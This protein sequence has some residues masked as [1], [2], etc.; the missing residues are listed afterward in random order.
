VLL[1]LGACTSVLG[2][3]DLHDGPRPGA[4]GDDTTAGTTTTGG[5][6]NAGGKNGN[7]GS[8]NPNAGSPEP[9]AGAGNEP[10]GG[11]GAEAGTGNDGG[12]GGSGDNPPLTGPVHGKLIDRWGKVIANAT[13]QIG[14]EQVSSDDKGL[15]TVDDVGESYDVSMLVDGTGWVFQGLTLRNPTLQ[16]Y[17]GS[18]SRYTYVDCDFKPGT[19]KVANEELTVAMSTPTGGVETTDVGTDA[20]FYVRPQWEGSANT[21]GTAHALYWTVNPA[22]KLPA[23][24]KAYDTKTQA[25][26]DGID[27]SLITFDIGSTTPFTAKAITG[28]VTPYG[29][30]SR[31]NSVFMRFSSGAS[32]QIVDHEPTLDAFSYLAPEQISNASFTVAAWEGS[33]YGPLGLVHRNGVSPGEGVGALDI[34]A[35]PT[36]LTP[37]N[38]AT[39]VD[40][41]TNFSFKASPDNAGTFLVVL[42]NLDEIQRLYIVTTQ[43][44]FTVPNVVDGAFV[45]A[46]GTEYEWWVETHGSFATVDA[47]AGPTGWV[48]EFSEEYITPVGL[49]QDSGTYTYSAAY[50]FTTKP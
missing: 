38:S 39:N 47:M 12:T 26:A 22:T 21:T 36:V 17:S 50:T 45:L 23:V 11:T 16:I 27:G 6:S 31:T 33:Y 13:V 3:E 37:P 28:T 24:Y 4:G 29:E 7:G 1:G 25:L 48:D 41:A 14:A 30:G 10:S 15:F 49:E 8:G 18:P 46:Q 35:P 42:N 44:K 5:K 34:P 2:I 20:K 43:K 32:I 40:D 19:A 9:G